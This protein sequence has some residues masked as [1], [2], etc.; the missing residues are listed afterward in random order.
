[1][2]TLVTTTGIPGA[3]APAM[4]REHAERIEAAAAEVLSANTRRTYATG[5]R[6]W[7]AWCASEDV[8]PLPAEPVHVGAYLAVRAEA[9]A[10][11]STLRTAVAAIAHE[12]ASRSAT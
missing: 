12:H 3:A 11:V 8:E 1:M 4:R 6:A 2:G 7:A 5:W 10:G 9:G